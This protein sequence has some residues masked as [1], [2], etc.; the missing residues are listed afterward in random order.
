MGCIPLLE[1]EVIMHLP[2][3]IF[4]STKKYSLESQT[5]MIEKFYLKSCPLY[6]QDKP[7]LCQHGVLRKTWY[8]EEAD[9]GP[10]AETPALTGEIPS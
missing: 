3:A 9:Y 8:R 5:S 1:K 10:K 4:Q 6:D 7:W 2:F